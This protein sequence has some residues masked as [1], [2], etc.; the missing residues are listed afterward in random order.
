MRP[1][2]ERLH[3]VYFYPT[4]GRLVRRDGRPC[5][6]AIKDYVCV[7]IDGF[8]EKGHRVVFAMVHGR[9][10]TGDIDH[11]NGIRSDNRPENLRE[12]TE[13]QNLHNTGG[14]KNNKSGY[15]GV[16]W[17]SGQQKWVAE[18]MVSRVRHRLGYFDDPEVAHYA[19]LSASLKMVGEHAR[20]P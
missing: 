8:K 1:S 18:I 12:V 10:P 6:S 7:S 19:Y 4:D 15:K 11:I 9:W 16:S 5:A 3:E 13:S 2:I 17:Y 20:H 14:R